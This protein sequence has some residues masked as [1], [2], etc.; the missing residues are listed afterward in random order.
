MLVGM[1]NALLA[2]V[3]FPLALANPCLAILGAGDSDYPQF[4]G[5]SGSGIAGAASHPGE[6]G[7]ETNLAWTA[8]V[9]GAGWSQPIVSGGRVFLTTAVNPAQERPMGMEAGMA[10]PATM[11][12]GVPKPTDEISFVVRAHALSD[13]ELLWEKTVAKEVPAH[14]IHPS[15]TYATE[16]P[17]T[18]GE[19]LFV[20]FAGIGV[21][22]AMDFDGEELWRKDLGSFPTGEDFGSGS[23]L[24]TDGAR[25]F[26]KWDNEESSFLAA[27]D[28]KSGDE[29]W[30]KERTKG[31]SW[32]TPVLLPLEKGQELVA[33]GAGNVTSY[34]PASGE[35]RWSVEGFQGSFE[36]SM[37][38]DEDRVYFGNTSPMI[39]G[40]LTAVSRGG[41]GVHTYGDEVPELMAWKVDRQG[42]GFS[43]PVSAG[44]FLFVPGYMG[45]L[46]CHD[47]TTGKRIWRQRLPDAVQI[48]ACPWVSGGELYV[49]D[50]TGKTFVIAIE[51]EYRLIRTNDLPGTY[52][53][54]PAAAGDSLLFRSSEQL[55]C[56]RGASDAGE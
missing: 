16:S 44:G 27:F 7:A 51:D 19:R 22:M 35:V 41:E 15:N 26:A 47:A 32:S 4:R 56:I 9:P 25:V 43:S 14:G 33:L 17:A 40:I 50:E 8:D 31:T 29:V 37:A 36:A 21:L 3:L 5:D 2:S 1:S 18:D 20:S 52:W 34:D 55:H 49:L 13:G 54:T 12:E 38:F 30:R 28:A 24:R 23:S 39:R 11:G 45:M 48:A 53:T 46:S 10:D 6:W 42:P